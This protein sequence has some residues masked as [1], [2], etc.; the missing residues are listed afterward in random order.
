[1]RFGS[2]PGASG[3]NCKTTSRY[4]GANSMGKT[5]KRREAASPRADRLDGA[6]SPGPLV[7]QANGGGNW[8][9]SPGPAQYFLGQ[10]SW[11][12]A[13]STYSI[14]VVVAGFVLPAGME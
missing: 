14:L 7:E 8:P 12:P 6:N 3:L 2:S 1:M 5:E 10:G 4:N 9:S 11:P 13:G